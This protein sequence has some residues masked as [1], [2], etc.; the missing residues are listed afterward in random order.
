MLNCSTPVDGR[1][2]FLFFADFFAMRIQAYFT[3][4]K[5]SNGCNI[6]QRI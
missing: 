4:V 6:C 3:L 5:L 2:G 1:P